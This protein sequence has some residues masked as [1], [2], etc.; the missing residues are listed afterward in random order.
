MGGMKLPHNLNHDPLTVRFWES[1]LKQQG[2][3]MWV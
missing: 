2:R 1:L 3:R